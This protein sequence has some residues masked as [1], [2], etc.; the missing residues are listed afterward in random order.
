MVT[1]SGII[2]RTCC[3]PC[4][5]I[6]STTF[7]PAGSASC[8]EGAEGCPCTSL[9]ACDAGLTC[10]AGTCRAAG[11]A[12]PDS[13]RDGGSGSESDAAGAADGS[14]Q[15]RD[16]GVPTPDD[17]GPERPATEI[18]EGEMYGPCGAQGDCDFPL[19]CGSRGQC[20]MECDLD[21]NCPRAGASPLAPPMCNDEECT[22]GCSPLFECPDGH[23]AC[24]FPFDAFCTYP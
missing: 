24:D 19:T 10:T 14:A 17:A 7:W 8:P 20:T 15:V 1:Q 13:G 2:S 18:P 6:S 3:A 4:Q 12:Q 22:I 5:S 21:Q 23:E 16:T 11:A 9:E